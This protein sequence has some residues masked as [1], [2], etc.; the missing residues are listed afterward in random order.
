MELTQ[1]EKELLAKLLM[2]LNIATLKQ[3][4]PLAEWDLLVSKLLAK[5]G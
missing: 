5:A 1:Q 3:I 2:V 4:A